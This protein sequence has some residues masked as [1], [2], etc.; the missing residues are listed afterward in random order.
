MSFGSKRSRATP[1]EARRLA[2]SA[3]GV[4]VRVRLRGKSFMIQSSYLNSSDLMM[5]G[6]TLVSSITLPMST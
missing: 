3:S 6:T 1:C 2:P 4:M 5:I